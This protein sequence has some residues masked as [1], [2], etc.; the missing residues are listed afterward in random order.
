MEGCFCPV[1]EWE[2]VTTTLW[3]VLVDCEDGLGV[4]TDGMSWICWL[5][6]LD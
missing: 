4:C 6:V 3:E 1:L 5:D 2:G